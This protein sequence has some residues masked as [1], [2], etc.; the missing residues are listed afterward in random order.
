MISETVWTAENLCKSHTRGWQRALRFRQ[1]STLAIYHLHTQPTG[2][3]VVIHE[4]D[5]LRKRIILN[6]CIR[7]QQQDVGTLRQVDGLVVCRRESRVVLVR[8][9][10]HPWE[11]LL[12]HLA[13]GVNRIV[14]HHE[15]LSIDSLHGTLN[16][17]Q[18]LFEKVPDIIADDDD[19]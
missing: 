7:I 15:H 6:D 9:Q 3:R 19:R 10:P 5:H 2:F 11:T 13:T 16:R 17:M 4:R 18:A 12:H 14:V 1:E 8:D